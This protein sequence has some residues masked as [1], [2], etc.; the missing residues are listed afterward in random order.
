MGRYPYIRGMFGFG[1]SIMQRPFVR[2][3]SM[4]SPLYLETPWPELYADLENVRPVRSRT[5]LRTQQK[6]E[7][8]A[9]VRWWS[10]GGVHNA[11]RMSYNPVD[12]ASGNIYQAFEK[13]LPLGDEDLVLDLPP[14]QTVDID[15]KGKPLAVVR[16][17]TARKE[18]LNT[19]RNPRPE[20]V[21]E[22]INRLSATHYVVAIADL[23]AGEEW[24]VGEM[25]VVDEAFL[26]GE[27]P[28]MVALG[29]VA[30][31]D[32]VVGGVGWIVPASIA[33]KTPAFIICGGQ[34]G[35]NAPEVITDPRLDLE[36]IHFAVPDP[37]CRCTKKDHD[38]PRTIPDLAEQFERW[39]DRMGV[40]L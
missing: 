3:A 40:Q 34:G 4:R 11:R 22:I 6:N 29:L 14:L 2:A 37:Y 13:H 10:P 27:L 15:T 8:S 19:A 12:L 38:C 18:W 35:H 17:V 33:A 25:P 24:L 30:D 20:Y 5:R 21:C 36:A 31:A 16:P 1:D 9:S 32:V 23:K 28:T 39:A 7:V 26:H